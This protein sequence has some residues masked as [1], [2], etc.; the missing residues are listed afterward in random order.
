MPPTTS[1]VRW[2]FKDEGE[3][4]VRELRAAHEKLEELAR[5]VTQHHRRLFDERVPLE[6]E[7]FRPSRH[8]SDEDRGQEN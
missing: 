8:P 6:E 7:S 4:L 5:R 1:S 2:V 3:E